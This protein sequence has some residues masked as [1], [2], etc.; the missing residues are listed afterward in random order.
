MLD[1]NIC[2]FIIRNKSLKENLK[3]ITDNDTLSISSIVASELLFGAHKKDSKNLLKIVEKFIENF[4][5]FE[6]D[7]KAADCYAKIRT[8]LEKQGLIIGSNDLLIAAHAL[9]L[10]STLITNNTREFRRVQNLKLE[11]WSL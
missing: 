1:T 4:V 10:D 2:S 7:L 3:Q 5:V 8:T 9:S 6:Y 11:D